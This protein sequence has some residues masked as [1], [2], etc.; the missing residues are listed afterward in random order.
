MKPNKQRRL[1]KAGFKVGSAADFL[2]LSAEERALVDLKLDLVAGV[3]ALRVEKQITQA[4]L[5]TLL[6]SSQSR[7]A[8]LEAGDGSVSFD[9]LMR[10]LLS[11]GST[12]KSIAALIASGG[13]VRRA[14]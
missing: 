10:A 6:G 14:S 4:Q 2:G 13:R 8:K 5:A 1:R 12:R 11:L 7:V 3:K 9:L